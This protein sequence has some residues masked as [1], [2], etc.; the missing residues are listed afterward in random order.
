MK[1]R[2][3]V[4]GEQERERVRGGGRGGGQVDPGYLQFVKT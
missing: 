4:V 3:A 1:G 2:W